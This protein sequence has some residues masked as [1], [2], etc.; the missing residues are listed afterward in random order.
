MKSRYWFCVL[1]AAGAATLSGCR[2]RQ[3]SSQPS[4]IDNLPYIDLR[5]GWRIRVV[6]PILKSGGYKLQLEEV[7]NQNGTIRMKT[8]NDFEGYET[9][10]YEVRNVENLLTIT[11]RSAEIRHNDGSLRRALHPLTPLFRLPNETQYV[12]LL[13][14]TRSSDRD[15][16]QAILSAPSQEQ[17]ESLTNPVQSNP[18]QLCNP[19]PTLS[20]VWVPAGGAVRPERKQGREWVPAL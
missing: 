19:Q 18:A 5:P 2:A 3:P 13:F 14:L 7:H 20:C 4:A 9:D 17:L 6:A 12:R 1:A 16:D 11:F 15:H 10:Y 8:G